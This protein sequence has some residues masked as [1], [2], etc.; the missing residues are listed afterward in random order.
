MLGKALVGAIHELPLQVIPTDLPD[1][2]ITQSKASEKIIGLNPTLV[3]HLAAYT[4]VDGAELNPDRAWKVNSMGTKNVAL[5]C[6][7]LEIPILYIS[8]DYIFDGEKSTP[9]VE[10]DSPNPISIYG[11]TKLEGELWIKGLLDKYWILRT[12][13][14]YGRGGKSFVSAIL[15]NARKNHEIKVVSDQICSPTY[16]NDLVSAILQLTIHD[17]RFTIHDSQLDFGVYHITNSEWTSW[18]EFAQAII[19]GVQ[20]FEPL[21]CNVLPMTSSELDRPA[22]RPR[23]SRLCNFMWE[24][25]SGKPLRNWKEA[26]NEYLKDNR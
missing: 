10:W 16:A 11:A 26:L 2:D 7:K 1:L 15:E 25:T 22:K 5:A 17:S 12:S 8:T 18:Y 14:L 23:N 6:Q 4:D 20:N 24:R 3:I 21:R 13:G 19:V 9:Y